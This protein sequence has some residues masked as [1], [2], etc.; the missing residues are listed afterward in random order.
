MDRL[1]LLV[2][3]FV[4]WTLMGSLSNAN[5]GTLIR[6]RDMVTPIVLLFAAGG[7]WVVARGKEDFCRR[8]VKP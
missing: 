3:A 7:L 5:I 8:P 1:P 6:L 2:A 4:V